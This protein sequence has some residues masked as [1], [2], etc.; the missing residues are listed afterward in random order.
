MI[1]TCLMLRAAS[2]LL[3]HF[4]QISITCVPGEIDENNDALNKVNDII[5][6]S[7]YFIELT[8][9]FIIIVVL[10]KSNNELKQ[11]VSNGDYK[12]T[13]LIEHSSCDSQKRCKLLD[14]NTFSEEQ[15]WDDYNGTESN[16]NSY[17]ESIKP[18]TNGHSQFDKTKDSSPYVNPKAAMTYY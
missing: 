16:L 10:W 15:N 9:S 5:M 1:S 4:V 6:L 11:K 13:T 17:I 2:L 7:F 8:P 14:E 3:D 12:N 18:K